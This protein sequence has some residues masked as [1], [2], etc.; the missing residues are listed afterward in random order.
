MAFSIRA[1][2]WGFAL[3]RWPRNLALGGDV[4]SSSGETSRTQG[5]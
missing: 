5:M 1:L 3:A 4:V 2:V